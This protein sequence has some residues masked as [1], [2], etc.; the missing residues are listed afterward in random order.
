MLVQLIS[1]VEPGEGQKLPGGRDILGCIVPLIRSFNLLKV[2]IIMANERAEP[3]VSGFYCNDRIIIS[4]FQIETYAIGH[5]K[6]A[7]RS[8]KTEPYRE[9]IVP[10]L[11]FDVLKVQRHLSPVM[12]AQGTHAVHVEKQNRSRRPAD[13]PGTS[14]YV[15]VLEVHG[16]PCPSRK[17]F[18][19][20]RTKIP[21]HTRCLLRC[22]SI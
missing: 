15:T 2:I 10:M 16:I 3:H 7:V 14:C 4:D 9:I 11:L 8:Q 12:T 18:V 1:D 22:P 19:N 21:Y 20:L 17:P 13:R 5:R 6:A